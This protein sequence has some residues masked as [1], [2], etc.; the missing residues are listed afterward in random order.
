[1]KN[2]YTIVIA[3]FLL[4]TI[5]LPFKNFAQ[6][7]CS[8]GVA[9]TA[10]NYH[11]TLDTT[12][13]S[14]S[15]I[16]FPKFNPSVGT[17]SCVNFRDTLSGITTTNA[18]NQASA[19]YTYTFILSLINSI[20]GP[21]F[22]ILDN[23]SI[24]YGPTTLSAQ[25]TPGDT[26]VYGPNS[27]FKNITNDSSTS[28][29]A[30]YVGS[31]GTVGFT[32]TLG[33]NFG[34]VAGTNYGD[35]IITNYWGKFGLTY[36]YCPLAVSDPGNC[37]FTAYHK[38]S[39]VQLQWQT[40]NEKS[41]CSYEVQCSK[42]GSNYNAVD[43]VPSVPSETDTASYQY[44]YPLQNT[45]SGKLLFRVKRTDSLGNITYTAIKTVNL[46]DRTKSTCTV[47]P[48]PVRNSTMM[49]F[50]EAQNGTFLICLISQTGQTVLKKQVT[51]SGTN[52]IKINLVNHLVPGIYSLQATDQA[53]SLQYV[54]K[55]FVQ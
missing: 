25:G 19:P 6:C 14:S 8:S 30:A 45:S 41:N 11:V 54:C 10:L 44:Q 18:W 33:G 17:L 20:T 5:F 51:L 50:D 49:E 3:G 48:N 38:G 32:Y 52:Q 2:I 37:G 28:N 23:S 16:S 27:I 46:D 35:Q 4:F 36:Y 9:A 1:M 26:V 42:G 53:N 21:G 29:T 13:A 7:N 15:T 40:K 34:T 43:Q 24:V 47:Y 22:S 55:V 39:C 31:S 12:N